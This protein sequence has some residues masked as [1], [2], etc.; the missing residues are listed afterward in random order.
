M[1]KGQEKRGV[2]VEEVRRNYERGSHSEI[3]GRKVGEARGNE[4]RRNYGKLGRM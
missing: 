2:K 1:A 3:S 4:G